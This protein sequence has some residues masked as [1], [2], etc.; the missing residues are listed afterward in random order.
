MCSARVR[1]AA[2]A[3]GGGGGGEEAGAAYLVDIHRGVVRESGERCCSMTRRAPMG[4]G[5]LFSEK[6]ACIFYCCVEPEPMR[7]SECRPE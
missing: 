1:S 7:T 6:R 3:R 5:P 2:C 4:K